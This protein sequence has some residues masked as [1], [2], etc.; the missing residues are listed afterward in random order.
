MTLGEEKRSLVS[1]RMLG[2]IIK[3]EE[4]TRREI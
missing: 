2:F 4:K 3:P 1:G